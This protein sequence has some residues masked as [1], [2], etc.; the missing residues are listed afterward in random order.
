MW[1]PT[2]EQEAWVR[3]NY[4]KISKSN[5]IRHLGIELRAFENWRHYHDVHPNY[6]GKP[7]SKDFSGHTRVFVP[8]GHG[9]ETVILVRPGRDPEEAKAAY[10]ARYSEKREYVRK[11]GKAKSNLD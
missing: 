10:I 11:G 1:R 8:D 3:Q 9:R 7:V 4:G 2:P 5:I 6:D